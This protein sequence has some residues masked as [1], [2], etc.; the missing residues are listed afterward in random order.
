MKG[1]EATWGDLDKLRCKDL[2][3]KG[4][5]VNELS[6]ATGIPDPI[7]K[8]WVYGMPEN[9]KRHVE[10]SWKVER[11]SFYEAIWSKCKEIS[12]DRASQVVSL[13]TE[14]IHQNVLEYVATRKESDPK[15]LKLLSDITA[16]YHRILL[17]M[18][19]KPTEHVLVEQL[20]QLPMDKLIADM[21]QAFVELQRNDPM[22]VKM[23]ESADIETAVSSSD[24]SPTS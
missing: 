10:D 20:A 23:I 3:F 2:Y 14:H 1:K 7:I 8:N 19:G 21:Q 5:P 13:I 9:G 12:I 24:D 4:M 15:E 18:Q 11:A 22:A 17:L 6:L 16:N